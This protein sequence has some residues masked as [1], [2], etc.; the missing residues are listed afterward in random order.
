MDPR[1][2]MTP[3]PYTPYSVIPR[4][5]QCLKTKNH[6]S[7]CYHGIVFSIRA[8]GRPLR[9]TGLHACAGETPRRELYRLY[10]RE[11]E[12]AKTRENQ[13]N[14]AEWR[15]VAAGEAELPISPGIYGQVPCTRDGIKVQAGQTV[16]LLLH[17]PYNKYGV[18]FRSFAKSWPGYPSMSVPT[19]GNKDLTVL[20]GRA[21]YSQTPFENI[22]KVGVAFCGVIEY[23][24]LD[25]LSNP[26]PSD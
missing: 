5:V 17:S 14:P 25:Q 19:D 3:K 18:A 22:S 20:V 15:E 26:S 11:G 21:T 2:G 16:S 9:I 10:M 12:L 6:T 13:L 1:K 23:E 4:H 24:F 8:E 7:S